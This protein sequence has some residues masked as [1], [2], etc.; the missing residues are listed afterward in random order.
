M[1]QFDKEVTDYWEWIDRSTTKDGIALVD[2]IIEILGL[3][4][5]DFDERQYGGAQR[6]AITAMEKGDK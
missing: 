4:V 1:N 2:D 6:L 5:C 3:R